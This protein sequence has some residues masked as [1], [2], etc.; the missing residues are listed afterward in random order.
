ME[1]IRQYFLLNSLVGSAPHPVNMIEPANRQI[2]FTK[3][4]IDKLFEPQINGS[5]R[6]REQV[7]GGATKKGTE[8]QVL[9]VM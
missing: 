6:I 2:L 4:E 5:T 8:K 3:A 7:I 9:I 1:R